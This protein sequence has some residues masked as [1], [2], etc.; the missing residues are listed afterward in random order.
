MSRI[1]DFMAGDKLL[2]AL[3]CYAL[4]LTLA[5]VWPLPYAALAVLA[6]GALKEAYD[7]RRPLT[8][9]ADMMDFVAD[10]I[11]L[12]AACLVLSALTANTN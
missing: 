7:Y 9:T 6:G 1:S 2:H 8:H 12:A 4:T 10:I 11:G 5:L 3:G